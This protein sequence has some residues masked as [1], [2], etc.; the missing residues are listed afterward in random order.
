MSEFA[1]ELPAESGPLAGAAENAQRGVVTHITVHGERVA[2]IVPE[3]LFE[4]VNH[5]VALLAGN[6]SLAELITILP[7][8]FPWA[9]S[10]PPH[11]LS[12]FARELHAAAANQSTDRVEPVLL[13]W[14]ATADVYADPELVVALKTPLGDYGPVPQPHAT[15]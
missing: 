2:A 5:L 6:Q 4:M 12:A 13:G 11:E 15:G 9:R 8:A 3:S 7:A 1:Y 10:L 14:H